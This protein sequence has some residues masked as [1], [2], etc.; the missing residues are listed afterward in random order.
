MAVPKRR[1]SKT[2]RDKRRSHDALRAAKPTLCSHCKQPKV[3]HRV[4][5]SCGYYA[6]VEVIE[7]EE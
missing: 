2:R 6:G 5:R 4:C 7:P 3:A 1:I